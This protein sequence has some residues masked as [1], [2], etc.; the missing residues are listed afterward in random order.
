[1]DCICICCQYVLP[2][3]MGNKL[4]EGVDLPV[5]MQLLSLLCGED[6]YPAVLLCILLED[7]SCPVL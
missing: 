6:L 1:M 4:K 5:N 2:G 3:G 7:L